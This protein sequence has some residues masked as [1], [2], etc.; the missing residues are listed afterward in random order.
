MKLLFKGEEKEYYVSVLRVQITANKK[1]INLV[2]VYGLCD[3][4]MMLASNIP[5][6]SKDEVIKITRCYLN[7]W[8]IEEYFKFK[9]QEYKFENFR[10]RSL[11]SINSLNKLLTY[12]IGLIAILSEK[13]GKREFVNKIIKES[14]SL[15]D[16]VYLWFYQLA[17]GIYNILSMAKTGIKNWQNIRKKKESDGQI[18][19]L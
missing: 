17:R 2:L 9:K 18:S 10:V 6:K 7:R 4:P 15:K 14:N 16:K 11:T 13:I 1:W 12:T 3:T 5:I 19:L 8:R